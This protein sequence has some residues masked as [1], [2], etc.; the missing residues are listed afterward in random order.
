M[1]HGR[2]LLFVVMAACLWSMGGVLIKVIPWSP[3]AIVCARSLI[4]SV[5]LFLFLPRKTFRFSRIEILTAFFYFMTV[6]LFVTATKLTTAA[7]AI[8]LQY[9]APLHVVVLAHF[10]LKETP[11][12]RDFG[13][14]GLIFFGMVMF[15]F[16]KMT[17]EGFWGN[18]SA[19]A[20]GVTFAVMTVQMRAQKSAEPMNSIFL[21]NLMTSVFLLPFLL[22]A[23]SLELKPFV[24]LILL[25]TFQLGLAYVCYSK[26]VPYVTAL[27][28]I[29][30]SM[31]EPVL[32]PLWVI[33]LIGEKP[34]LLSALGGGIILLGVISRSSMSLR[35]A[36]EVPKG[37]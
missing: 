33:L 17:L 26:A 18:I 2:A 37:P 15:F 7:N 10:F 24:N 29:M 30:V 13:S 4:A 36:R 1:S 27:E 5:V 3:L 34:S 9:T 16:E 19:L 12:K 20:S 6:T 21:G 14:L 25:G 22:E 11:T 28:G 31:L 32:N 35:L 8:F 23:P